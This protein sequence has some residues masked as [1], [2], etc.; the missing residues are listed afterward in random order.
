[1]RFIINCTEYSRI[2]IFA[3]ISSFVKFLF[4]TDFVSLT[5][6]AM[7]NEI[8]PPLFNNQKLMLHLQNISSDRASFVFHKI[9]NDSL[10]EN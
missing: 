2:K 8:G 6:K 10:R 3:L 4:S 5:G 7:A 9:C 1:M